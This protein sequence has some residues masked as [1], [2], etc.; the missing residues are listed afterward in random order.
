MDGCCDVYVGMDVVRVHW[1]TLGLMYRMPQRSE[2]CACTCQCECDAHA[3]CVWQ[4]VLPH[5]TCV[6]AR[7]ATTTRDIRAK[8]LS[9]RQAT[10]PRGFKL[11]C[12]S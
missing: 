4:R 6:C 8:G 10:V 2:T 12:I 7:A 3:I 5:K 1:L 11:D 9:E